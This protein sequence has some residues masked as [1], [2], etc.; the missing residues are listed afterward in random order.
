[1]LFR[2]EISQIPKGLVVV[3]LRA[4]LFLLIWNISIP[5]FSFNA[6]ETTYNNGNQ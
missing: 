1:M 4:V 5:C 3:N 6:M 2:A